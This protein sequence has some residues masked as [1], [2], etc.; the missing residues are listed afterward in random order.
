MDQDW[1]QVLAYTVLGP[2]HL[3]PGTL[4]NKLKNRLPPAAV[5]SLFLLLSPGLTQA[6]SPAAPPVPPV[7]SGS[8]A[9]LPPA[10]VAPESTLP[11]SAPAAVAP[12]PTQVPAGSTAGPAPSTLV[13]VQ[14]PGGVQGPVATEAPPGAVSNVV[15][16][17]SASTAGPV[18]QPDFVAAAGKGLVATSPDKRFQIGFRPRVQLRG[19]LNKDD[20]GSQLQETVNTL[21]LTIAGYALSQD[22]KYFIQFAF[23]P[24][25]FDGNSSPIFDAYVEYTGI[26]D[27]NVKVGQFFTPFDRARTIREFALQFVDRQGVV[28]E[29]SLDRDIGIGFSSQDLFGLGGRLA[30]NLFLGGGDGR[31]RIADTKNKYGPQTPGMLSVARVIVRPWGQFDDDQ[32][33]DLTRSAT[34]HMAIGA[35]GAYNLSSD[36]EKST[37]GNTYTL[38]TFNYVHAEADLVFK[39]HGFS[40]LTEFLYREANKAEHSAVVAGQKVTERSRSGYGYFAQVGQMLTSKLELTARA[41]TL[42]GT[43][44]A[45]GNVLRTVARTSG[46]QM[47]GG[48]NFYLNGHAFKLQTDYFYVFGYD[49]GKGAHV[50]RLQLDATF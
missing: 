3:F 18:E 36:R 19:T 12:A 46:R 26:R 7:D 24:G 6:Q 11:A 17:P 14:V 29:F 23:G 15:P 13:P 32:E 1:S 33:G 35:A 40:L 44:N 21:R 43:N 30:Y 48:L 41:E 38:G 39:W 34:P 8:N 16:Y 20:S 9:Y 28:R 5:A 2:G 31:D 25:D 47:G 27:F 10:A 22:L 49:L 42:K 45:L 50:A 37:F 4:V